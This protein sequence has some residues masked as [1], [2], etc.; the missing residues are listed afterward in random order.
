MPKKILDKVNEK[1]AESLSYWLSTMSMFYGICFLVIATLFLQR[2]S[3]AVGWI[4]YLVSVLF[5]GVA[6][7]VLGYTSRKSGEVQ[8]RLLQETHDAVMKELEYLKLDKENDKKE[9]E[10]IKQI[11]IEIHEH[12]VVK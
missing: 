6:L 9:M 1:F 5:Q 11:I 2:P 3:S 7:P 10:L 4:Q 12:A 8:S